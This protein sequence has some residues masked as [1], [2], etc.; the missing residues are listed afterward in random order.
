M[1]R[2][3]PMS[4]TVAVCA[5]L[6]Q[7]AIA[8]AGAVLIQARQEGEALVD[9][10]GGLALPALY[11][12]AT[13]V[14][15]GLLLRGLRVGRTLTLVACWVML[16]MTALSLLFGLADSALD[17]WLFTFITVSNLFYVA[18]YITVIQ[19]LTRPAAVHFF[20]PATP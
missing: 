8:V 12:V 14:L 19:L 9:L 15:V 20:A 7:A 5:L 3:R 16:G 10:A 1:S 18:V 13:L 2:V 11:A 17:G 4:V 6:A